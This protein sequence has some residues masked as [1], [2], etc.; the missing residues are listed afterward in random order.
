MTP[1]IQVRI[2]PDGRRALLYDCA[3]GKGRTILAPNAVALQDRIESELLGYSFNDWQ[4][5]KRLDAIP[6]RP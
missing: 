6:P 4:E 3:N 5:S 2:R 1:F